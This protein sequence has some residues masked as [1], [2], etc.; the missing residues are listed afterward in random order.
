LTK[1]TQ[2]LRLLGNMI[3]PSRSRQLLTFELSDLLKRVVK[4]RPSQ[5][6]SSLSSHFH[7]LQ[8]FFQTL[9]DIICNSQTF[10]PTRLYIYSHLAETH[11]NLKIST[12]L[13]TGFTSRALGATY[14]FF[15]ETQPPSKSTKANKGCSLST[16]RYYC[17]YKKEGRRR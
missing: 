7:L 8:A 9:I 11:L 4:I 17:G 16:I 3:L 6:V 2:N 13:L 5:P 12:L 1:T 15:V 10:L 14:N